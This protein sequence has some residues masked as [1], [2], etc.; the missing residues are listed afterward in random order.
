MKL[1]EVKHNN[2]LVITK[3]LGHGSFRK[4]ITEMGFIRGNEVR[5][6][7]TSP[8][9]GPSEFKI[10][11]Y[12]ITLRKSEADLIEVVP[13]DEFDKSTNGIYEGTIDRNIDLVNQSERTKTI[14]IALVGNP[15]CGKTT[16][17]NFISGSK[18]KVGNYSGV[19]VDIHKATF[20]SKGYTFNFFDLPGTYSLT[21]YSKEEIFVREFIYEQTPDI[22]INVLDST[23]L[24]RSLFLTTQLI[25]MDLRTIIALNMF[26][27]LEKN[28]LTLDKDEL[29]K[30]LGIP[31]I[32]TVSSKG[33]GIDSLVDKVIEVFEG[34]DT[35]SR[36]IHINYGKDLEHSLKTIRAKVREDKPIT[37]KISSRFLAIKLIEKDYQVQELLSKYSNFEDIKATTQKEIKKIELLENDDSETVITN[38]KYSFITGALTETYKNPAKEKKTRS[39]KIDSVLTNQV[40]GFPIFTAL[41]FFMF[42]TTFKVGAYP[43]EWIDLGVTTLG[44][45][46]RNILPTGML[47]DLLVD[48]IINGAGS[49]LVFLPNILILFFFISLLEGSGYMARAAF[50]MDTIMHRFGLHGRS[51]IPMIMGFGCNV[52]AILA[53]RSMRNR[54]DRILTM[55]IIPFMSCSARLPVYILIISAFFQKNQAL[56]LIGLY[57]AGVVFA[58]LT[59]QILN[60]TVFKNKE[61][62]FVMELPTYRLPTLRNV[63]YHMWDKTQHYLKKIGTIIL[64]GVVIVWTLE[65]FPRET[66]STANFEKQIEQVKLNHDLI[67][68]V[69]AN[70]I[71]KLEYAL[72]SDRLINSYIGRFGVAI[73]PVMRPL[74]FDWKMSIALLAGLPAKE[75]VVSTMG[76]LYQS[77]NDESTVNL[78]NKLQD[79]TYKTGNKIGQKVFTTPSALAF[80]IFILI[81]F[82]CIGVV[83]TIKNESGSWKWAAFAVFYTTSLAWIA[84][85]LVYNIGNLIV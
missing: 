30:L 27:E 21:A 74:G 53:T 85:F 70:E 80:L 3:V 2:P 18:E 39:E 51:F 16:L 56:I 42:W 36:H 41:L 60:K 76:V 23:N 8:F 32:P 15:N 66:E 19:T 31:I 81:Y 84:A 7:K 67:P 55:L 9:N 29:A 37:D 12:N 78:Q 58:F 77:P 45:F 47:N 57:A 54:G 10:L 40:L 73:E 13:L 43:M 4:R 49:V 5:V 79:E 44:D 52:P 35:I 22:V 61:T 34:K 17:F 20:K 69:K 38:A 75:I 26:D 33:Q 28:K 72:E 24:E 83:A 25:D 65:Y 82:P 64:L 11:N 6:I 71:E 46:V 48:G 14:N 59:A 62:P 63:I 1:S 50:I 68:V